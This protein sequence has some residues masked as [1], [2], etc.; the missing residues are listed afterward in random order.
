[1]CERCQFAQEQSKKA[2]K[3]AYHLCNE[4]ISLGAKKTAENVKRSLLANSSY[5]SF[6]EEEKSIEGIE[7]VLLEIRKCFGAFDIQKDI[8]FSCKFH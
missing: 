7:E 6:V 4:L 1:M 5:C 8:E 2:R 3:K